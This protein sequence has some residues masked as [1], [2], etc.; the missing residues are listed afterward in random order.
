MRVALFTIIA[1]CSAVAGLP[2]VKSEPNLERRAKLALENA[3]HALS[4]A[5]AAYAKQDTS[6]TTASLKE[7]EESIVVAQGALRRHWQRSTPTPQGFQAGRE[8]HARIA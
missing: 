1:V 4:A 3:D 2:E 8:P 6:S 7:L 5:R